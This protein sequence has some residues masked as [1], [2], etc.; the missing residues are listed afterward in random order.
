MGSAFGKPAGSLFGSTTTSGNALGSTPALSGTQ[1]QLSTLGS[2][3]FGKPLETIQP[4]QSSGAGMFGRIGTQQQ[5]PPA[6]NNLFGGATLQTGQQQQAQA[7]NAAPGL[8]F[9]GLQNT[10]NGN[11]AL[12]PQ[13]S[14][15]TALFQNLLERGKSRQPETKG[16][17]KFGD[18]PSL[19]LGLSDIADKVRNLGGSSPQVAGASKSRAHYLL[20]ASGVPRASTLRDLDD[21][22]AQTQST[23]ATPAPPP[24]DTDIDA[25]V[26]SLQARSSAELFQDYMIQTKRDFDTF[27]EERFQMD[28][29]EQRQRIYEH[30]G[31]SRPDE[32]SSATNGRSQSGRGAFGR[33]TRRAGENGASQSP[34]G[35]LSPSSQSLSNSVLGRPVG[36]GSVRGSLFSDVTERM[37]SSSQNT[38]LD[39]PS[40]RNKQEKYA[41][42]VRALNEARLR[43]EVYPVIEEFARVEIESSEDVSYPCSRQLF[44][45]SPNTSQTPQHLLGAYKALRRITGE[46][47]AVQRPSD[48]GAIRERQYAKDYLDATDSGRSSEMRK[49]ILTGAKAY[50]E[51]R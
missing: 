36:R 22:G 46:T 38:A 12:L 23:N 3:L 29:Y 17:L 33:S 24:L 49:R 39:D 42:K 27:I 37:T 25:Y 13:G 26:S 41:S 5:Q 7:P 50:L 44:D 28:Q 8:M 48:P 34:Y 20:A 43:E 2:S 14:T 15:T 10:L 11:N 35:R 6:A 51:E 1:A 30:F 4:Q 32:P 31:L 45:G 19:K 40:L 47:N 9:G 18:L 21:F 16:G